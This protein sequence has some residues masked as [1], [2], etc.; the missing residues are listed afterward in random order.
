M[1][2]FLGNTHLSCKGLVSG[3]LQLTLKWFRKK[4]LIDEWMKGRV[5]ERREE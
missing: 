5:A 1:S 3:S 2:L 4:K